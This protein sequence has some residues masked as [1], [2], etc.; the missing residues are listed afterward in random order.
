MIPE[1]KNP[2]IDSPFI[3]ENK[4]NKWR[5]AF[6]ENREQE[7]KEFLKA[8]KA[9]QKLRAFEKSFNKSMRENELG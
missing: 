5:K 8:Y 2:L 4:L 7:N 3:D 9:T 6:D 1:N